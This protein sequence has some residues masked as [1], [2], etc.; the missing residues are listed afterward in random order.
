MRNSFDLLARIKSGAVGGSSCG[1]PRRILHLTHTHTQ[2]SLCP[3]LGLVVEESCIKDC[4]LLLTPT[5]TR[6]LQ[7][8]GNSF[9]SSCGL[10][11]IVVVLEIG[12]GL[13][14]TF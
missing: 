8:S 1:A 6:Y 12:L 4:D 13:Q 14:T 3:H 10:V 5:T 2:I 9:I 11:C 7:P